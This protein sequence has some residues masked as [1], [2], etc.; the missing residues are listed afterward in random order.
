MSDPSSEPNI[1]GGPYRGSAYTI[2]GSVYRLR[3]LPRFG[4][5]YDITKVVSSD[6]V[7]Q[8]SYATGL[9]ALFVF[10]LMF[11]IFWTVAIAVLKCMGPG[12][13]GFLSGHHFVIPDRA[14]DV[15][16]IYKRP[17]R[18]RITFLV[19]CGLLMLFSL[20]FVTMG[21]TNVD[22]TATTMQVSL[23][24]LG[25]LT[26]QA[27]AIAR[28][29]ETVGNA[30]ISI[31]DST[32]EELEN[33]CPA[34]PNLDAYA[35]V[36]AIEIADRA[37]NDLTMLATFIRDGLHVLRTNLDRVEAW[38]VKAD[39]ALANWN[40]WGWQFKLLSA[41][42]FILPAFLIIGVGLVM[43]DL[44]IKCYQ[45]T[46]TYGI[47]P[48]FCLV[49]VATY[50]ISALILPVSAV[51]ADTCIGGGEAHGGPDDTF[52]TMYRNIRGADTSI[53]FLLVAYYTQRC[54][55]IYYPFGEVSDYL[56]LLDGAVDSTNGVV[57][58]IQGNLSLL[59]DQCGRSYDSVIS[60][61]KE[62]NIS[63]RTLRNSADQTLD[64]IQCRNINELYVNTVHE[65]TCT[66][67]VEALAWIFASTLIIAVC[68]LIIIMLR[69]AYYPEE[70][71]ELSKSWITSPTP[72]MSSPTKSKDSDDSFAVDKTPS[73]VTEE[74]ESRN[75][76]HARQKPK[77]V[78][79]P[80]EYHEAVEL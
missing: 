6:A 31:R 75:D 64:L 60:L 80:D 12:N 22:N 35:G 20:L 43:L 63:L 77:Y 26:G 25:D 50:I 44:D 66:Y 2:T 4:Y 36:N 16:N 67:S 3:A 45:R 62:I 10:I 53:L 19:A 65:A 33:F 70:Y 51:M 32:V 1:Y 56:D 78:I 11:F 42:L 39:D 37:K 61:V 24:Q 69:A 34:N 40:F 41:G 7:E 49:I 29:L 76:S 13:A 27:E 30:A 71:L 52:L 38:S 54:N 73:D 8:A 23:R 46:L 5:Q 59:L 55:S 9:I 57:D 79:R 74:Q 17:L 15:N 72:T 58:M 48:L 14:D 47:T 28:K 18:V 21:L 68:G